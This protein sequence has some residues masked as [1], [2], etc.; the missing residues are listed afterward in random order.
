MESIHGMNSYD[1]QLTNLMSI[2]D[3][4]EGFPIEFCYS[5]RVDETAMTVFLWVVKDSTGCPIPDVIFM[6]DDT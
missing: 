4:G 5:N 6:S 2:D 1:F 3:H